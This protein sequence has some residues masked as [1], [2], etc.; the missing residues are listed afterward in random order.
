MD[1]M[2]IRRVHKRPR[3]YIFVPS[4]RVL[5]PGVDLEQLLPKRRTVMYREGMD[6]FDMEDQWESTSVREQ[7]DNQEE[8]WTGFTEFFLKP[9]T[10]EEQDRGDRPRRRLHKKTSPE[11][12]KRREKELQLK[13]E[14][15]QILSK[16]F[17]DEKPEDPTTSG[18]RTVA[19]GS[20]II[21][22]LEQTPS[23]HQE[24]KEDHELNNFFPTG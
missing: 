13:D 21:S 20:D 8:L 22:F 23:C 15:E 12:M 19:S 7:I 5:P 16:H 1:R 24:K 4:Q 17:Q 2:T 9:E 3:R 18:T 6:N 14:A 11:E 10:N